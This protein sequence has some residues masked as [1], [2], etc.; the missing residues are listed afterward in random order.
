[1][2]KRFAALT[3]SVCMVLSAFPA[4]G[5]ETDSFLEEKTGTGEDSP[6][7]SHYGLF[8]LM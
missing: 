6:D 5:Q 4:F 3:L 7:R 1:M 8:V 2:S